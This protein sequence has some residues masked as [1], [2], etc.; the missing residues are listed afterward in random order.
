MKTFLPV[1]LLF[2]CGITFSQTKISGSVVDDNNQPIPG[3]NII[4]IGT[5]TGT[6]TDFDGQFSLLFNQNLL[7]FKQVVLVLPLVPKR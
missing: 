7:E 2:V 6:V 5:S 1:L 3:A 4:V